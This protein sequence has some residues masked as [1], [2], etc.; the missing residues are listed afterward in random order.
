M[1][2]RPAACLAAALLALGFGPGETAQAADSTVMLREAWPGATF[3]NPV[4]VTAARDGTD[5]LFIAQR[6]GK[7]LV[8]KKYR[9]IPPVP[10][11]TTYLDISALCPA[12]F[13]E[14]SQG[15][16]LGIAVHP[17]DGRLFVLYGTP[18]PFRTVV[19]S[20]RPSANPDVA[21]PASATTIL[22]VAKR[23]PQHYGGGLAF[24]ADGHLFVGIG[25][26]ALEFDSGN[27]AQDVRTLEGKILRLDVTSPPAGK[28]YGIP[29]DNP[30]ATAGGGVRGEIW[31]FGCRNPFRISV[32]R[33]TGNVWFGDPGQKQREEVGVAPRGGN[34]GWP[35]LE[36]TKPGRVAPGQDPS[37]AVPPVH[38]YGRETGSC[39]IGG[40]VYR[41]QR[42][43]T[44][45]GQYV[46]SDYM[47][48]K[49]LAVSLDASATKST[50]VREL[51]SGE[52]CEWI[53]SI[54]EDAQGEIYLTVLD[55]GKVLTLAPA[56]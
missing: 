56:N 55:H 52:V 4:Q 20:Y 11:P 38:D 46:F 51:A 26:Q 48:A 39:C 30:W 53:C 24:G 37:K 18:E 41:G 49:L 10:A 3:D 14:K 22:T 27:V 34:M 17:K 33:Q 28:P 40:V 7:I 45:A 36:G 1:R 13:V 9:G 12:D 54:D 42:C 8:A 19:A 6:G 32:D 2:T 44:L 31:A 47:K 15:G 35:M 21:D 23:G 29:A 5:R 16:L 50:G 43:P 25:D